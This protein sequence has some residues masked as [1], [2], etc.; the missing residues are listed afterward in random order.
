MSTKRQLYPFLSRQDYLCNRSWVPLDDRSFF[1][2]YDKYPPYMAWKK[3]T[4]RGETMVTKN[5]Y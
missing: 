5:G 3:K 2:L 1:P 4:Q